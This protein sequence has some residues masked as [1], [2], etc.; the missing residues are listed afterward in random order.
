MAVANN[1]DRSLKDEEDIM[2]VLKLFRNRVIPKNFK[3]LDRDRVYLFA[4][5][6]GQTE[7]IEECFEKVSDLSG[8]R[9]DFEL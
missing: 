2:S 4:E 9:K 3:P 7:K 6:F 1:P 8:R 5:R